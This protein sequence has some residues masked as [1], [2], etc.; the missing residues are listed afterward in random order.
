MRSNGLQ[1]NSTGSCEGLT[2][3]IVEGAIQCMN[4]TSIFTGRKVVR[5]RQIFYAILERVASLQGNKRTPTLDEGVG[6]WDL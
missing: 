5:L 6:Q 3:T 1:I 2:E 4:R